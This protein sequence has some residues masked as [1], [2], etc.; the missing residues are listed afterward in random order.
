MSVGVATDPDDGSD[1]EYLLAEAGRRMYKSNRLRRK[2]ASV[3]A[4]EFY[5]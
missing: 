5:R 1:A 2:P 3:V 4:M